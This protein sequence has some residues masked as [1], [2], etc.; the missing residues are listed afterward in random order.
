MATSIDDASLPLMVVAM[1]ATVRFFR[2]ELAAY[3]DSWREVLRLADALGDATLRSFGAVCVEIGTSYVGPLSEGLDAFESAGLSAVDP[4]VGVVE[5]G[6]SM[7]DTGHTFRCLLL[8]LAGHL[9]E[10]GRLLSAT[11]ALYRERPS[12]EW[13]AW[14]LSLVPRLADWTGEPDDAVGAAAH[15]A[16][17][18]AEDSGFAAAHV[19]ALQAMG[20][21]ELLH[22]NPSGAAATFELALNEARE[23]GSGLQE[24]ASL[25]AY[26]TRALLAMGDEYTARARTAAEEAV[27]VAHRQG[28]RVVECAA[29]LIRAQVLREASADLDQARVDLDAADRL[30]ADTGAA[31]Y[32]ASLAEER[33]RLDHDDAALAEA[34]RR[35][36]AIGAIGHAR[37]LEEAGLRDA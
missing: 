15:E 18:V 31:T 22:G 6:L 36:Q 5:F 33:A 2:G 1:A 34:G 4:A 12:P 19:T 11:R 30:A 37:R 24:E 35:Y 23:H 14:T 10:A 20:V 27:A 26:L 7:H 9:D 28:A 29:L 3:L 32:A 8:G 25:L 16:V 21:A 13:D 17:R